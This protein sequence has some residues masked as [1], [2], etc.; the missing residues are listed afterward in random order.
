MTM[1]QV[2]YS[3]QFYLHKKGEMV[4]FSQIDLV[5]I[6][7]RALRRTNLPVYYTQGFSP[8]VKMSFSH[9]LKVGIE[10]R[11]KTTLYF[12][13]PV[14]F[15]ALRQCFGPQ[16]PQGLVLEREDIPGLQRRDATG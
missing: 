3:L 4:C 2:R 5:R 12:T 14:S 7:E 9:A 8:R 6:I 1:E 11:I 15:E 16:L 13:E 10:G